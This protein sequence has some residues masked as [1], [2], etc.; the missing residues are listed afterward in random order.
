MRSPKGKGKQQTETHKGGALA[1]KFLPEDVTK[2]IIEC[3]APKDVE[4]KVAAFLDITDQE[5][6]LKSA[7][8]LDYYVSAILWS[9]DRDHSPEQ[10]SSVY[11]VVHTLLE[12]VKPPESLSLLDN[13]NIM[14][15]MLADIGAED[16]SDVSGGLE[17]L[18]SVAEA[19]DLVTYLMRTLFQHYSLFQFLFERSPA[20]D[21]LGC[22]LIVEV[23]PFEELPPFPPP[24]PE[25]IPEE[26][27]QLLTEATKADRPATGHE[28]SLSLEDAEARAAST[29]GEQAPDASTDLDAIFSELSPEQ[30]TR[31]V[32]EVCREELIGVERDLASRLREKENDFIARINKVHKVAAD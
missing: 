19:R 22:D 16:V 27:H 5:M 13:I 7:A 31:I 10:L 2:K 25:A 3:D 11:S 18:G 12:N 20:E 14:K 8:I 30:V 9:R 1:F 26:L 21:I 24:L 6:N 28:S 17:H 32:E 4:E 29:T 23:A 15:A